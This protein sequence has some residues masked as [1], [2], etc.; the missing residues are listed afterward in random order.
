MSEFTAITTQEDFDAAVKDRLKRQE[1][2][3]RAE[4]TDSQKEYETYKAENEKLTATI[5]ELTEKQNGHE[6][7]VSKLKTTIA[8]YE[9]AELKAKVAREAG[10]PYEL[11]ERLTGDDEDALKADAESLKA[12]MGANKKTAPPMPSTEDPLEDPK[13]AQWKTLAKSLRKDD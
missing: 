3:I 4:Y 10:L 1:E 9:K 2:K 8:G 7:E 11:S 6:A 5:N 13:D 12:L